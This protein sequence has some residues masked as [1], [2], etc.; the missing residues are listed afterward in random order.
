MALII[1]VETIGLPER[2]TSPFGENPPYNQLNKYDSARMVQLSM[3]LC[4]E[5]L[6]QVEMLDFIIKTDGFIIRNSNF[7]GITNEI[8]LEKGISCSKVAVI[9]SN[10]L[11]QVS[12]I[13]AHNANFDICIIKSELY[14]LSLNSIIE[15]INSKHV[16]CTMK[17]TKSIV[18]AKN[19]YNKIKDPSL[20]EL[21]KFT[22]NK[23]IENAHNS[24]YDVINLHSSIK[25]LYD[26]NILKFNTY[27]EY[28][29]VNKPTV[30]PSIKLSENT[31]LI[32]N[33]EIS[34]LYVSNI[35]VRKTLTS[36]EDE[37]GIYDL[38]NDINTN[39]LINPITVRLNGD[40]YEII[41]G[42]RRYLAMKHLNNTYI[43][44]NILNID[45]QKAEEISLV[46]NVQR[47]QMT[48]CDKVR[49]YSKLYDVY[50]KDIDRVISAIH[51]SKSTIQ[52]YLK[53]R[54]LPEEVLNLL[55]TT[56]ENKI[57]IDVAIELTKLPNE[58][59]TLEVLNKITTLT[60]GQKIDA[61]KQ[62]KQ[63]GNN[64]ID[65]L[66]DIKDNVVLHHNNI[67][68]APSFPYVFDDTT[69]KNIRIPDNMFNE[70][71]NLIKLKTGEN[72][73]YC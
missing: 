55:D 2:G 29:S 52:K 60:N 39:G 73:C 53:M 11:K 48:T 22:F 27:F 43:P 51:I 32:E 54:K 33:I 35:N 40:M 46:E 50:N 69:K 7:H 13:I 71:V 23:N 37:T 28:I 68:L 26:T 8:S 24:N 17:S 34:K 20:A 15:E 44:C 61:I 66:D 21:Y 42:Q 62:F 47:N 64:D 56:G 4:N 36:E 65:N 45:T 12:H 10:K 59:N 57:S 14:R 31:L 25:Q 72:L 70:I 58:V 1:D 9:L 6:E 30:I 3:M 5:N 16:V 49:S 18:N 41:A 63:Q 19:K 38:A 67:S